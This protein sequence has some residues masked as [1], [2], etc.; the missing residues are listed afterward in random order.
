MFRTSQLR[1][2]AEEWGEMQSLKARRDPKLALMH[3][4]VRCAWCQCNTR[5]S[6]SDLNPD[7][8]VWPHQC[9]VRP[10]GA[11]ANPPARSL[12]DDLYEE[13]GWTPP[14]FRYENQQNLF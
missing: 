2:S 9:P 4:A 14:R 3:V 8:G 7:T 1:P 6:Y 10:E 5:V 11:P 13:H 12:S